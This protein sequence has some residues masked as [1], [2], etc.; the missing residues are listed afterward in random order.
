MC[1]GTAAQSEKGGIFFLLRVF[2]VH[3]LHSV[4]FVY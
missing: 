3:Q 2:A 1:H 4:K